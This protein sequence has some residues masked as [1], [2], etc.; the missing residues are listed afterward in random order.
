MKNKI[1][2]HLITISIVLT[3]YIP[4]VS[5]AQSSPSEWA[6]S[7]VSDAISNDLVTDSVKKDYQANITREQFCEMVVLAYEKISEKAAITGNMSFNDTSNSEI[8]K[9][10]NLGIVEGYG[11]GVFAPNDL[12]TREQIAVM[13][14]RMID[15][16]V[17]Y[18]NIDVYNQNNF[19]DSYL[20]SDWALPSINFAYDNYFM[21]G[22]GYNCI[23]PQAN[24]TCEQAVLLVYRVVKLYSDMFTKEDFSDLFNVD[25]QIKESIVEYTNEDG[26][27]DIS[28]INSVIKTVEIEAKKMQNNGIV[29]TYTSDNNTVWMQLSNGI[30]YVFIPQIDGFDLGG[31]N[32]SITTY[33]PFNTWYGVE[34]PYSGDQARGVVATDGSAREIANELSEYKFVNNYDDEDVSLDNIKKLGDNQFILWHGH[35]GYNSSIHSFIATGEELDEAKFLWDPIYYIKNAKYTDDYLTGRIVCTSLGRLAITDKFIDKYISSMNNSFVYIGACESGQDSYLANSL[36]NKGAVA[37]IGNSDT[38][39]T[40]YNQ[41][42]IQSVCDGLLMKSNDNNYYTLNEALNYAFNINGHNDSEYDTYAVGAYPIIFGDSEMRL[43]YKTEYIPDITFS[44]SIGEINGTIYCAREASYGVSQDGLYQTQNVPTTTL[45]PVTLGQYSMVSSFC[46]YDGYVYYVETEGGTTE[47][48]SWLYRCK[49]DWTEKELLDEIICDWEN[50]GVYQEGE[51]FFV[52][53]NGVLYYSWY[54]W[55]DSYVTTIDLS[56][57]Q[58]G[59]GKM[60][61]Y[62]INDNGVYHNGIYPD[63]YDIKIYNDKIFFVDKNNKLYVIE[64][65]NKRLLANNAYLDGGLAGDYLYFAE[66]NWETDREVKLYRISLTNGEKEYIDSRMP[67]GGG[68][69]YFCW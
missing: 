33:Q 26:F 46:Y 64:N 69:P 22:V 16:A 52:I 20:I 62:S 9:A 6:L 68:G 51:R 34:R 4:I 48:S 38:I 2:A 32:M 1:L 44:A 27:V 50:T 28:D 30:Q 13:L 5:Y 67:A 25:D 60:P 37:V 7:E 66:W 45:L 29:N 17:Q 56:S 65:G 42:M 8:L 24:T 59:K 14:V 10:A 61:V 49:P 47:Y 63:E 12:I 53:D 3:M 39:C 43:T 55:N 15:K 18:E 23:D 40:E 41:K 11:N 58:K 35:G 31:T 21:R 36:L 57:L 54:G 19:N